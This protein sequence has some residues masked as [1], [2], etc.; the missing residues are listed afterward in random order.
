MAQMG[1][2]A[3][4]EATGE[5]CPRSTRNGANAETEA[6]IEQERTKRDGW[7]DGSGN[8]PAIGLL[9]QILFKSGSGDRISE[10]YR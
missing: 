10:F 1:A 2:D 5:F 3:E 7:R 4:K 9:G 8:G 6:E